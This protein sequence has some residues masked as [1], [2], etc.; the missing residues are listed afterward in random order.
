MAFAIAAG[1]TGTFGLTLSPA[2]AAFPAGTV[3]TWTSDNSTD[4]SAPTLSAASGT[5]PAGLTAAVTSAVAP[6][7]ASFNLTATA[8]FPDAKNLGQSITLT[9]GPNP[10]GLSAVAATPVPTSISMTQIS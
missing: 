8:V 7:A 9:T 5:L 10:V 2:G 6:V 4:V 3:I 1:A